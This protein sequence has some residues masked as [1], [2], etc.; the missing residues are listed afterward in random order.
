MKGSILS[1][2]FGGRQDEIASGQNSTLD[3]EIVRV[4]N[5]ID[6]KMRRS[7]YYGNMNS[8]KAILKQLSQCFAEMPEARR[9]DLVNEMYVQTWIRSRF[10]RISPQFTS[11]DIKAAICERY[12]HVGQERVTDFVDQALTIIFQH[13]PELKRIAC[14]QDFLSGMVAAHSVSNMGMEDKYTSDSEYGLV[15]EKPV[16]VAGFGMDRQYLDHLTSESGEKLSYVRKGS[17]PVTGIDG[18]VDIYL[19]YLPDKTV[20]MTIYLSVYGSRNTCEVPLG[21]HYKD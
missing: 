17:M 8:A 18:P 12:S 9:I 10:W 5:G 13:D 11:A 20:Y 16:F 21:L 6:A 15:P 3:A 2:L 1:R 14:V 7:V 19:L 4:Y